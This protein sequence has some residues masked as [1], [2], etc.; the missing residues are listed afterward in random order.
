L[1]EL[2][3]GDIFVGGKNVTNVAP[4]DR[5]IAMVFQD[6]ALYP[7][8]N[9]KR[10]LAYSLRLK[11]VPKTEIEKKIDQTARMLGIEELLQ[12]KPKELSG[13]QKQRVALGRAI[14]RDPKAFLM[15]EPLSNLDAKL[16][17]RMRAEISRLHDR[18]AATTLYVTH[19]QAEAMTLADRIVA[20]KDGVVQ[21]IAT[22]WEIYARPNNI[23]V[24]GFIGSP[25]MNF[26]KVELQSNEA[27]LE[28]NW[29]N[30]R[31]VLPRT[32]IKTFERIYKFIGKEII[33]GIR[34]ED[35]YDTSGEDNTR[36]GGGIRV[37]A[38][39]VESLGDNSYVYFEGH[40]ETL[41][42]P[43][44]EESIADEY[45]DL[46]DLM[47]AKIASGKT[48]RRGEEIQLY[49]NVTK[50]FFFDPETGEAIY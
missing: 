26:L 49:L 3:Y 24:A 39:V 9:V 50:L 27:G 35:I 28:F 16:R 25:T 19:D 34:P 13:G 7:H 10:N 31:I 38:R 30:D 40:R 23:F 5:D 1:E 48:I 46:S 6:Y 42:R 37:K 32:E 15:D 18:L 22:P 17:A 12:R 4:K 21:Q 36:K 33:V 43:I 8:M 41:D 47:S 11:R 45:G 44:V 14:V 2:T 20:L 29:N